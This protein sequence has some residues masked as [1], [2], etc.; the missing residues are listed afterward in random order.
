MPEQLKAP[1][2]I[3]MAFAQ[4]ETGPAAGKPPD[5]TGPEQRCEMCDHYGAEGQCQKF[6]TQV[7]EG[8]H[9]SAW[10]APGGGEEEPV[11]DDMYVPEPE[12]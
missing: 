8:G 4:N 12:E 2:A 9:C 6:N 11:E 1:E 10:T 5:Y 7:E 3:E